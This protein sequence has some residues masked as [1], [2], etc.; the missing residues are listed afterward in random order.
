MKHMEAKSE[1]LQ[2]PLTGLDTALA[3]YLQ[4][5]RPSSDPR[6]EMLAA[7]TSYQF[8]RGHACL[9][10]ELLSQRAP[11]R[12]GGIARSRQCLAQVWWNLPP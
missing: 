4:E 9:D 12:W 6:H 7:L 8:G 2:L 10:L 3:K 5:V 1:T 11:M